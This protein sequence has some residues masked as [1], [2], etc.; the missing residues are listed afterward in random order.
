MELEVRGLTGADHGERSLN[1]LAAATL[2]QDRWDAGARLMRS[3]DPA[4]W[5]G[6]VFG[7][8]LWRDNGETLEGCA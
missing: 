8:K 2:G 6:I 1:R 4:A 5:N 7:S 3:A